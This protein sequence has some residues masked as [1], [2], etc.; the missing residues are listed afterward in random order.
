MKTTSLTGIYRR[1]GAYPLLAGLAFAIFG[2]A[3]AIPHLSSSEKASVPAEWANVDLEHGRAVYIKNCG[4]CHT[5]HSP[6]E[7]SPDDWKK[8]FGEMASK[9]TMSQSD[10][11]AVVAYLSL[12]S[13]S[14]AAHATSNMAPT[15]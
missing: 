4:A 11:T 2:C 1:V 9:T 3:S 14:Y 6:A 13:H 8:L 5:L 15:N 7:H 10:S 12:A